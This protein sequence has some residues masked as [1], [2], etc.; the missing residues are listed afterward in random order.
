MKKIKKLH[1]SYNIPVG[2]YGYIHKRKELLW[3]F[4]RENF[5][6]VKVKS[7]LFSYKEVVFKSAAYW[8][9]LPWQIEDVLQE[10]TLERICKFFNIIEKDKLKIK[11][12]DRLK[13]EETDIDGI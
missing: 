12:R 6:E 7:I 10:N 1:S 2:I 9:D 4:C 3:Y 13:F 5:Q 8:V 11:S